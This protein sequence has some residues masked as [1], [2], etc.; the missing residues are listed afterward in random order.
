[1]R[2]AIEASLRRGADVMVVTQPYATGEMRSQHVDQQRELRA[3]VRRLFAENSHVRYVDLSGAID[4]TDSRLSF[5]GMHLTAVG[6]ARLAG[7]LVD[8]VID[9]ARRAAS[10]H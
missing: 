4:L 5:D 1:M 10:I 7:Q 3:M 6:N 2:Q 9:L 8:P